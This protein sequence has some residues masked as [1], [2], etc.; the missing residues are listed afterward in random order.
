LQNVLR[1]K[2][3]KHGYRVLVIS[4]PQRAL[5][6]FKEDKP[7]AE[8]VLLSAGFL[9]ESA[10]DAFNRFGDEEQTRK[11]PAILLLDEHQLDLIPTAQVSAHRV[12]LKMPLKVKEVRMALKQLLSGSA[13][14]N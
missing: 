9:G 6:R 7:P 4:D 5:D 1:D 13:A 11:I 8:C 12:L 2:L 10:I 14:K 3:K